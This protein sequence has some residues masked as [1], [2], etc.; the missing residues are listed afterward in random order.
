MKHILRRFSNISHIP[1]LQSFLSTPLI[2]NPSEQTL[3]SLKFFIQTYGCQMNENDSEIVSGILTGAG[4]Q[5][6]SVLEEVIKN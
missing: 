2:Q 5:T 3:S 1:D 6:T 4:L